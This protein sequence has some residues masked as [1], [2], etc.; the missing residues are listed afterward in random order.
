MKISVEDH[1]L[2][3]RV[4]IQ[5]SFPLSSALEKASSLLLVRI[6]AKGDFRVQRPAFESR[7]VDSVGW[8]KGLDYYMISIKLKDTDFRYDSFT[9]RY[10]PQLVIDI[11]SQGQGGKGK[12][13]VSGSD[14]KP[15]FSEHEDA[16][17]SLSSVSQGMKTVIIDPGHGGLN[18]GAPGKS[19]TLEKTINLDIAFK[20]KRIIEQNQIFRVVMTREKDIDVSLERRAA[21]ANN[22]KAFLF[23]SIHANGSYRRGARGPETYFL[24]LNATDE[25]ARRLAYLENNSEDFE[26]AIE[27]AREDDIKLILWDMAQAAY[28]KQSSQLAENIQ[29]EL[30]TLFGTRNR[31]IKQAPFKVLTGVACPAILVEVA[32][33][34]NP[35]EERK[36]LMESFQ[37]Q[38]A[39][40]MHRGLVSFLKS[41]SEE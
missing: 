40:A 28:L 9:V 24:S 39:Q 1:D 22:N 13:S 12:E 8:S 31:G 27:G 4:I 17:L 6:R 29:R 18:N 16:D 3:S 38:I 5:S 30:N 20:L 36:L 41:I 2:Y 11:S 32:F 15:S 25:E 33:L 26:K 14:E 37:T 23:I 34:S 19:G 10:P 7:L 21:I 35:N